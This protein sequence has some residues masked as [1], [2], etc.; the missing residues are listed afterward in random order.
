LQGDL[1]PIIA[2]IA[3][4]YQDN[5]FVASLIF[6]KLLP[7]GKIPRHADGG[8]SLMKVH[9][10]HIPIVTNAEN[11]FFVNGEE[12]NMKVGEVWEINNALVHMVENRSDQERIHL[13]IDWMPNHDGKQQEELF[14]PEKSNHSPESQ[15]ADSETVNRML[16][17]AF[18]LHRSP[19]ASKPDLRRAESIYRHVLNAHERHVVA[20]NLLGLLYIQTRRFEEAVHYIKVALAEKIDDPQ[21]HANMGLALK[22]LGRFEEAADHFQ[23]ALSYAPA[24]PMMLNNLGNIY[25][26]LG[27]I[28]EAIT[29]YRQAL[30]IQPSNAEASHNLNAL[31]QQAGTNQ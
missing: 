16:A 23:K 22:D 31:M 19:T 21:A 27:R 3:E 14:S 10:I 6:A 7:G 25:K 5:G 26:E 17:E 13:I 12:K 30:S 28:D 24:N 8:Y 9:R 15:S 4:F 20:N 2:H 11:I 29:S 18:Q 1:K